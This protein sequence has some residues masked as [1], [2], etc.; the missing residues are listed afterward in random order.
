MRT[1]GTGKEAVIAGEIMEGGP[2]GVVSAGDA[3]AEEVFDMTGDGMKSGEDGSDS[4]RSQ[5][6]LFS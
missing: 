6:S 4:F 1:S 3:S 2:R 5:R